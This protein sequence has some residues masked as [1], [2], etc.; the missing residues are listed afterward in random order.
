MQGGH[1]QLVGAAVRARFTAAFPH[2]SATFNACLDRLVLYVLV[3][4]CRMADDRA[5]DLVAASDSAA[6]SNAG[7]QYV[8]DDSD[9]QLR[10]YASEIDLQRREDAALLDLITHHTDVKAI[11]PELD[12]VVI[13]NKAFVRRLFDS[14]KRWDHHDYHFANTHSKNAAD[15]DDT[16]APGKGEEAVWTSSWPKNSSSTPS[17]EYPRL[18]KWRPIFELFSPAFLDKESLDSVLEFSDTV[19]LR[20]VADATAF[21][22]KNSTGSGTD[23]L[24]D[25]A[26]STTSNSETRVEAGG[27]SGGEQAADKGTTST[28]FSESR[29]RPY[30]Y[31]PTFGYDCTARTP[32]MRAV[33]NLFERPASEKRGKPNFYW[34]LQ[35]QLTKYVLPMLEDD[36][37]YAASD[38]SPHRVRESTSS[39]GGSAVE[40]L[41]KSNKNVLLSKNGRVVPKRD[42]DAEMRAD[43]EETAARMKKT[44]N[45]HFDDLPWRVEYYKQGVREEYKRQVS[46]F[47]TSRSAGSGSEKEMKTIDKN[48]TSYVAVEGGTRGRRDTPRVGWVDDDSSFFYVSKSERQRVPFDVHEDINR[49]LWLRKNKYENDQFF[50]LVVAVYVQYLQGKEL[51]FQ[52]PKDIRNAE[53]EAADD[54][55][56]GPRTRRDIIMDSMTS[57]KGSTANPS[58]SVRFNTVHALETCAPALQFFSAFVLVALLEYHASLSAESTFNALP[59]WFPE[60]QRVMRFIT[61]FHH[62]LHVGIVEHTSKSGIMLFQ[63]EVVLSP[64]VVRFLSR[65]AFLPVMAHRKAQLWFQ[66]EFVGGAADKRKHSADDLYA[67]EALAA[68]HVAVDET[69]FMGHRVNPV[70][71]TGIV[72]GETWHERAVRRIRRLSAHL[73]FD[74]A[75]PKEVTNTSSTDSSSPVLGPTFD[76]LPRSYL[77]LDDP[78]RT[79]RGLIRAVN[80]VKDAWMGYAWRLPQEFMNIKKKPEQDGTG[81]SSSSTTTTTASTTTAEINVAANNAKPAAANDVLT[82]PPDD[83]PHPHP[84]IRAL[85]QAPNLRKR[86]PLCEKLGPDTHCLPGA[87][88]DHFGF[89]EGLRL[90][91][92]AVV[93]ILNGLRLE[94][95]PIGGTLISALRYGRPMETLSD[96]K[97][98]AIDDDIEFLVAVNGEDAWGDIVDELG[99]KLTATGLLHECTLIFSLETEDL[100]DLQDATVFSMGVGHTNKRFYDREKPRP[101]RNSAQKSPA[102]EAVSSASAKGTGEKGAKSTSDGR[103]I[104]TGAGSSGQGAAEPV[105]RKVKDRFLYKHFY[106]SIR[107]DVLQCVGAKPYMFSMEIKSFVKMY[108]YF[109]FGYVFRN[110]G[111][112]A[113][114]PLA[115]CDYEERAL[116]LNKPEF[117]RRKWRLREGMKPRWS[118]QSAQRFSENIKAVSTDTDS[119]AAVDAVVPAE[120]VVATTRTTRA[121]TY[122]AR[123]HSFAKNARRPAA[124]TGAVQTLRTFPLCYLPQVPPF[125]TFGGLLPLKLLYPMK[126]C[127]FFDRDIPCPND[128]VSFLYFTNGGE[129]FTPGWNVALPSMAG[130]DTRFAITGGFTSL[131]VADL[132]ILYQYGHDWLAFQEIDREKAFEIQQCPP[133]RKRQGVDDYINE[134]V[135]M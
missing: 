70:R 112:D 27:V 95:F 32:A 120:E 88:D 15:V 116:E 119:S 77:F 52:H 85:Q 91:T 38:A 132:E 58:Y 83:P 36:G 43:L 66:E 121:S 123:G 127:R 5:L 11:S 93:D 124:L 64:Q 44:S 56:S 20:G 68:D 122:A 63:R 40:T 76:I 99:R 129:Y 73:Q 69:S 21:S 42:Q 24:T 74:A 25:I 98:D 92:N 86:I 78:Y 125:Q 9:V 100:I 37:P 106:H 97:V 1:Q 48:T 29:K 61:A 82:T 6:A 87:R 103:N 31:K 34:L 14:S 118:L 45:A 107:S 67:R 26:S 84:T 126:R 65:D 47:S 135:N 22:R 50:L 10:K 80:R 75:A 49:G 30:N 51:Q 128:A 117:E 134:K 115:A 104:K 105:A 28:T 33:E 35:S 96:G 17:P 57:R 133:V 94:Y 18:D 4:F 131:Q 16:A 53:D 101:R 114:A 7:V 102:A 46:L 109:D 55:R 59:V 54:S 110:R 89:Q 13:E 41:R 79:M 23:G 90:A 71:A 111:L 130:R 113:D 12:E 39:L 72:G 81:V 19:D 60:S 108:P 2:L 8:V 3:Y 62:Q